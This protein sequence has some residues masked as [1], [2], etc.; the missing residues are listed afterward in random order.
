MTVAHAL[1][2]LAKHARVTV[3]IANRAFVALLVDAVYEPRQQAHEQPLRLAGC[4]WI[5]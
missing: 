3:G 2:Y 4:P 1:A 5:D